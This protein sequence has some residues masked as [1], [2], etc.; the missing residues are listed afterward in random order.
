LSTA[1][2]PLLGLAK[3]MNDEDWRKKGNTA[4]KKT[5]KKELKAE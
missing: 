4:T 3:D 2:I 1:S 5:G